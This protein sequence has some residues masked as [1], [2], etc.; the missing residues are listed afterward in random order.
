MVMPID[1]RRIL[2]PTDFSPTSDAAYE[3]AIALGLRFGA[4]LELLHVH[5]VPAYVFP[6]GMVPLS[7]GLLQEIDHSLT[8][9]LE[10]QATRAREAGLTVTT[11]SRIGVVHHEILGEAERYGAD[12]VVMGTH[13][14]TGLSHVLM[15]SVTEKVLRHSPCPVLTVGPK[16]IEAITGEHR[17]A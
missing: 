10:R 12:L 4:E 9:V 13:G 7:P 8:A 16:P 1:V 17:P 2:V 5:Q 3:M 14:R 11:K 15:G 6:D